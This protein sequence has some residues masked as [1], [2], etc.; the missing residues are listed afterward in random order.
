MV[1]SAP[2]PKASE[3]RLGEQRVVLQ[4]VSWEGYLQILNALPE[5]RGARLTYDDEVF[6]QSL[7]S[8]PVV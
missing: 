6:P 1:I 4:G 8:F 5:S 7:T 3:Q 2:Q